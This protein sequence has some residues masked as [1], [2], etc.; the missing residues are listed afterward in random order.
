[1]KQALR[2]RL[3]SYRGE[4][5][6]LESSRAF[7]Q[8]ASRIR[9]FAQRVDDA[10]YTMESALGA[11]VKARRSR[12]AA[13]A[14]RLSDLDLRRRVVERRSK[15]RELTARSQATTRLAL[16]GASERVVL[17]A[18]KLDSLSPLG[19]LARGYAIAFDSEGRI[20]K[21]AAD[22]NSG[23]MLRVRV[24]EGEMECVKK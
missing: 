11:A 1:M 4:L 20:V 19:V 10:A 18:G 23:D 12:H 21:R 9:S 17:A 8:V 22:V 13:L 7:D 3:L 16:D 6:R 2:Y 14:L 24:S 5:S 15:L